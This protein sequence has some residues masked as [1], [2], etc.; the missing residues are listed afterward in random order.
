MVHA[1][2]FTGYTPL[3]ATGAA[4]SHAV[5]FARDGV[6]AVATRLPARLAARG[7]W[8]QTTLSLPQGSWTDALTSFPASGHV[9]LA[10]L[11][12]RYPVAL[13]LAD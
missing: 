9:P 4:A 8:G 6:A 5:A 12:A 11:L 13:L 1:G 10:D 7:G 2:R 3:L